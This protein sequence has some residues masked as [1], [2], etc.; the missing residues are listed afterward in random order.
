MRTLGQDVDAVLFVRM[1][2]S[3]GD[4]W[5][6]VDVR[7]YDTARAALVDLPIELWSLMVLNQTAANSKNGD[8][9][10]NCQDLM[11]EIANKRINVSECVIANCA[12]PQEANK[13]LDRVLD[14]LAAKITDLDHKYAF[15]CQQ[16]FIQLQNTVNAELEKTCNAW[17][18]MASSESEFPIFVPLFSELFNNIKNGLETLLKEFRKNRDEV[19]INFKN[20]VEEA[21]Q[22]SKSDNG[23]P[24]LEQIEE[25]NNNVK[26]Y[27]TTYEKYLNEIRAHL[28]QHFLSL[29]D[30]LKRSLDRVKSQ[31]AEVLI[32]NGHFGGLTEARGSELI[33]AIALLMPNEL[34]PGQPSRVKFG[35]QMLGEFELSY[36]GFVQ[37]RIRQ[38]L[39]GLTPNE[40]ATLQ[41]SKSPNAQQVL[42]NLRTA[43]AEAVYKCE[44]ALEDLLCEP[45][46]A[47]FAIVEEFLDRIFRAVDVDSEWQ[48]FL[49]DVRSQVW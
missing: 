49:Y 4:Y 22:A 28:S 24:S 37:H 16:R 10:N 3:S 44:N 23:I 30:G 21:L 41:L 29:D 32:D 42:S 47:A 34:I 11:E 43:H 1:P 9:S 26:G 14:Y 5:A 45:S 8:N 7:L 18:Q 39:D 25:R 35:F 38:H 40:Q 6:D 15:S 31:V 48:I 17:G 27:G 20:K 2:K 33:K 46:Q 12:I 36:R 13:V 19:D